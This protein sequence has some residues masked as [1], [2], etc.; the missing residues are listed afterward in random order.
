M[1]QQN[2]P[3]L[4]VITNRKST[5]QAQQH[6]KSDFL[7]LYAKLPAEQKILITKLMVGF[8]GDEV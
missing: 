4:T 3:N 1:L 8:L 6:G 7:K 5:V 2:K